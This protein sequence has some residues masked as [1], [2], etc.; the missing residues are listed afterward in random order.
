MA[1]VVASVL[2]T[3]GT[4]VGV[5]LGSYLTTR[6]QTRAWLRDTLER[7]RQERQRTYASFASAAREWR[8]KIMSPG[9]VIEEA[10]A[11]SRG[12]HASG[13]EAQI[14]SFRL[15]AEI[16]MIAH[17]D[18]VIASAD[19]LVAAIGRLAEA[20]GAHAAGAVP[21]PIVERCRAAEQLFLATAREELGSPPVR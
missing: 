9:A 21:E 12:R 14:D 11:V 8:S 13:G 4:L 17:S 10:S 20:R 6:T 16:R 19:D 18:A 3:L 15:R 7:S 1:Q 5:L 2:A